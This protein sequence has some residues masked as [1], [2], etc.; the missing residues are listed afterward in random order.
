MKV[1][2]WNVNSVRKRLEQVCEL[3]EKETPDFLCLQEL[4]C[5][6]SQFPHAAIEGLDYQA[7]IFGQKSY[8]GVAIIV[9]RQ[10][11]VG[12]VSKGFRG[13]PQT[14]PPAA[15]F[16]SVEYEA[17]G[18]L[19]RVA[20]VYV[21]NGQEVGSPA[22]EYKIKFLDALAC[23]AEERNKK[24]QEN[25]ILC[26][27]FNVAPEDRDVYDPHYLK[28]HLLF[29]EAE[30]KAFRNLIST[31]QLHDTYRLHHSEAGQFS[32]WDYR[33]LS[34]PKNH[35]LR[36]DFILAQEPVAH[37]CTTSSILRNQ[38]KTQPPSDHAPLVAEFAR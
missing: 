16:L 30:K 13:E 35:G 11:K 8:N 33:A 36:I 19:Y 34:F 31:G 21:P 29:S 12:K 32:W 2:S 9:P 24:H 25:L 7:F 38:R 10:R 28:G 15:R 26:G 3:L 17:K 27:D 1:A 5:E 23:Y 37:T 4:K 14:N 6:D 22:F 20:S 18:K